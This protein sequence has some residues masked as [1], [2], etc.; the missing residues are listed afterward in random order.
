[1]SLVKFSK[2]SLHQPSLPLVK[3]QHFRHLTSYIVCVKSVRVMQNSL[4]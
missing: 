3:Q 1:M 2:P 4:V